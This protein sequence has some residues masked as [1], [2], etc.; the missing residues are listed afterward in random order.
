MTYQIIGMGELVWDIFP[1]SKRLGGA[2]ANF[3]IMAQQL[4]GHS[5]TCHIIS[6]VGQ[7][8]LGQKMTTQ[9]CSFNL[10][11]QQIHSDP[12][13]DTGI[14]TVNIGNQGQPAYTI[15]LNAAWDYI[16]KQPD[17]VAQNCDVFCFGSLAQRQKTS[18]DSIRQFIHQLR[19]NALCIFDINLRAPH[20]ETE[21][22]LF[23]L[24]AA[25][26]LKINAEELVILTRILGLHGD[27]AE[28]LKAIQSQYQLQLVI[29]TRGDQGSL[30]VTESEINQHP[31]YQ[32]TLADSVG[33]GDAFTAA[34]AIGLL[35]KRQLAELNQLANRVA[36]YVCSQPVAMP[37]IPKA[38]IDLF[39]KP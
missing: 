1:D 34:I 12:H 3:A 32:T 37:T 6:S 11:T 36:A 16:R 28:I 26:I 18:R 22:L 33:A 15:Q 20:Y 5:C 19:P 23:S 17:Q 35:Q 29:L 30:L 14:V 10:N 39:Q 31:G 8:P 9:L 24:Q 7:D 4:G 2:P 27:T 13:H 21:T 38:I 25:N